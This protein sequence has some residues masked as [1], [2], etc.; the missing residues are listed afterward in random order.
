MTTDVGHGDAAARVDWDSG[1]RRERRRDVARL[2]W[3]LVALAGL[4][5]LQYHPRQGRGPYWLVFV[6]AVGLTFAV[7]V[8]GRMIVDRRRGTAS[9]Y[10]LVFAI[11][12]HLDPGAEV[13]PRAERLAGRWAWGRS[14]VWWLPLFGALQLLRGTWEEPARATAGALV[15]AVG[16]LGLVRVQHVLGTAAQRWLDHPPHGGSGYV[17]PPDQRPWTITTRQAVTLFVLVCLVGT[18]LVAAF[19]ALA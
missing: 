18:A 13:R 12:A 15:M 4:A 14:A 17:P 6:G 16:V 8:L 19:L 1:I 5:T 9:H 10:R 3:V 7:F 2:A 11:S